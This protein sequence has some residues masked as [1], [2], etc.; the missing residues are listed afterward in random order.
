MKG[1]FYICIPRFFSRNVGNSINVTDGQ[2]DRRTDGQTDR[3]TDRRTGGVA[4]SP[5]PGL[6]RRGAGDKKSW[7]LLTGTIVQQWELN[8][9]HG[10]QMNICQNK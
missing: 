8:R 6:R 4:I 7:S 3:Q 10:N 9:D 5:V 2:T 1:H